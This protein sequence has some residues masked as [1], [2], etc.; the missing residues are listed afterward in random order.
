MA[1]R[2]LGGGQVRMASKAGIGHRRPPEEF[3]ALAGRL[4][5]FRFDPIN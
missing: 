1:E 4:P 3:E 2:M 5:V